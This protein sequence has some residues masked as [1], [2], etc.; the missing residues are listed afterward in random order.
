MPQGEGTLELRINHSGGE[1]LRCLAPDAND[2]PSET[3]KALSSP[4][5]ASCPPLPRAAEQRG[6]GNKTPL[7]GA[8]EA[9]GSKLNFWSEFAVARAARQPLE[10]ACSPLNTRKEMASASFLLPGRSLLAVQWLLF[11]PATWVTLRGSRLHLPA[12][13]PE[14]RLH[15]PLLCVLWTGTV[16][17]GK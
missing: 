6:C 4:S 3:W 9:F 5:L 12:A 8:S 11:C 1:T 7:F 15:K 14:P 10:S 13:C 2:T 17:E 16:P